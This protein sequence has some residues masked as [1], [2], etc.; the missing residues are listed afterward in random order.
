ML[1]GPVPCVGSSSRGV[2][3]SSSS[4]P[5]LRESVGPLR[6]R[7]EVA[8]IRKSSLVSS[9]SLVNDAAQL[10]SASRRRASSDGS[11]QRTPTR[12]GSRQGERGEGT[13]ES[14]SHRAAAARAANTGS[15][16]RSSIPVLINIIDQSTTLFV[17]GIVVLWFVQRQIAHT[18]TFMMIQFFSCNWLIGNEQ[19]HMVA[20]VSCVYATPSLVDKCKQTNDQGG[21]TEHRC[22]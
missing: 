22:C 19:P 18:R 12:A 11:G 3:S 1:F 10:K 21:Q 5:P 14:R 8:P 9:R 17:A 13:E 6:E 15:W 7:R 2:A 16:V 20:R 4:A